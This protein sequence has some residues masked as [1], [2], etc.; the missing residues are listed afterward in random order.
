L[1][2]VLYQIKAKHFVG[3]ILVDSDTNKIIAAAPILG[4]TRGKHWPDIMEKLFKVNYQIEFV[5]PQED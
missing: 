4:W 5:G 2:K 1:A 3:G